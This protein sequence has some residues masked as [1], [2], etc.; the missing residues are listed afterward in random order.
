[1]DAVFFSMKRAHLGGERMGRKLLEGYGL[2]PTRFDVLNTLAD[3]RKAM[4]QSELW[5]RLGVVRSAV[6]EMVKVLERLAF[7][8]RKR[9]KD[10]R[11]WLIRLTKRGREFARRA[12]DGLVNEGEATGYVDKIITCDQLDGDAVS[13]RYHL[14]GLFFAIGA[15]LGNRVRRNADL[16]PWDIED[17]YAQLTTPEELARAGYVNVAP[18]TP[19]GAGA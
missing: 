13:R 7:I 4:K 2:T 8:T 9:A 15:Q 6:C 10:S 19:S 5:K 16:Y 17:F 11:T 1:M 3:A 18:I 14:A 12:Y